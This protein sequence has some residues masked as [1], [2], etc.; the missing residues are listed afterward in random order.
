MV[1]TIWQR[2]GLA[3]LSIWLKISS[4]TLLWVPGL[5][6]TLPVSSMSTLMLGLGEV[7]LAMLDAHCKYMFFTVK[8]SS[9][10]TTFKILSGRSW[11]K[12]SPNQILK[13]LTIIITCLKIP[14]VVS[15]VLQ[16]ELDTLP[17]SIKVLFVG[18]GKKIGLQLLKFWGQIHTH[19]TRKGWEL[20]R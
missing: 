11:L 12:A 6:W 8:I 10:D 9:T 18:L 13:K 14:R 5:N 16:G 15:Q 3:K 7:L 4:E 1:I 17:G 2:Q 20:Q 19:G